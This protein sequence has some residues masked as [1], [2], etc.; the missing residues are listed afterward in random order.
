M[1]RPKE[2]KHTKGRK[3]KENEEDKQTKHASSL[4]LFVRSPPFI[5]LRF[6]MCSSPRP[7]IPLIIQPYPT[8][9]EHLRITL[10]QRPPRIEGAAEIKHVP[11]ELGQHQHG[12]HQRHACIPHEREAP[13]RP[14]VAIA[15]AAAAAAPLALARAAAEGLSVV[16]GEV[17]MSA[18]PSS[19]EPDRRR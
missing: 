2:K 5:T 10:P 1:V 14:R 19:T 17:S 9:H 4:L 7:P 15:A 13:G 8:L 6:V 3:E 18:T 11:Q 16:R 12:A